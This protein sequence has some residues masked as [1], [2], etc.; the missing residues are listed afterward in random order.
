MTV[1][2][3]HSSLNSFN[4]PV[5]MEPESP[6]TYLEFLAIRWSNVLQGKIFRLNFLNLPVKMEPESPTTYLEFL[7]IYGDRMYCKWNFSAWTI[8][9]SL[10]KCSQSPQPPFMNFQL[11]SDRM[12]C[13][14]NFSAW[15]FLSPCEN[16]ARVPN[17]LFGIFSYT[18]IECTVMQAGL[19]HLN[20]F[21][22]PVNSEPDFPNSYY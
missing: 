19:F 6:T 20:F 1:K 12:Q 10:W 8:L 13:K 9:I 11:Y 14:W 2:Q 17:Y 16:G 15:T 21:Y 22:L 18:V 4:L 7:A 3:T 5:E